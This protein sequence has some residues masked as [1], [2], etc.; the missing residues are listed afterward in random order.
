MPPL[1]AEAV[2]ASNANDRAVVDEADGKNCDPKERE[3]EKISYA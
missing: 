2:P 1:A 3:I